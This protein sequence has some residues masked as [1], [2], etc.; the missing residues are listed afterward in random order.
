MYV[1]YVVLAVLSLIAIAHRYMI[2]TSLT[3]ISDFEDDMIH[4]GGF[5]VKYDDDDYFKFFR[6]LGHTYYPRIQGWTHK[7]VV[8]IVCVQRN[9][10]H[11]GDVWFLADYR[12]RSTFRNKGIGSLYIVGVYLWLLTTCTKMYGLVMGHIPKRGG[13]LRHLRY[14]LQWT[15]VKFY[16]LSNDELRE[17][18][19]D[20]KRMSPRFEHVRFVKEIGKDILV[21]GKPLKLYHLVPKNYSVD[22]GTM[23]LEE[24][25]PDYEIMVMLTRDEGFLTGIDPWAVGHIV[26]RGF[27]PTERFEW[28]SS[29]EL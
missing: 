23:S 8:G 2:Q 27:D 12:V 24:L 11:V 29:A 25:N 6:R 22:E 1:V 7:V 17:H 15:K 14:F 5:T 3:D 26:H 16:K 18:M 13:Y 10:E 21:D 20:L 4:K 9:I 28:L 19:N